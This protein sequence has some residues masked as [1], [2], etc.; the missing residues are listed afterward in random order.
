MLL[1]LLQLL[2]FILICIADAPYKSDKLANK[3]L[4]YMIAGVKDRWK[5]AVGYDLTRN[6]FK[7]EF[8]K[9][10]IFTLIRMLK[11]KGVKGRSLAMDGGSVNRSL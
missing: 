6:S 9:R 10:R 5:I 8:V 2:I 4:V 3:A 1:F 7:K 11:E